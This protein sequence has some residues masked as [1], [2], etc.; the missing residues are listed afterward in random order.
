MVSWISDF[1]NTYH[2][3]TGRY[4]IDSLRLWSRVNLL[5]FV[6]RIAIHVRIHVL[7][8][9]SSNLYLLSSH[10]YDHGLVD[11]MYG[12]QRCFRLNKPIVDSPIRI[13]HRDIAGR[14]EVRLKMLGTRARPT[15][16]SQLHDLLAIR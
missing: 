15:G 6:R 16:D 9:G 2:A 7:F 4:V 13:Q 12:E 11:G 14:L 10:L 5:L 8:V 1:S 3:A